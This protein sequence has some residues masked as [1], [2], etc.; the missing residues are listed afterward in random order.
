[1]NI[2]AY[3]G[4]GQIFDQFDASKARIVN[5]YYGSGVAYFTDN[6]KVAEG[7]AKAMSKKEGSRGRVIY[8]CQLSLGKIFDVENTYTGKELKRLVGSNVEA[9]ARGAG[10]MKAGIGDEKYQILGALKEGNYTL[11]GDL[12]FKAMSNG[13]VATRS[14][15]IK[16]QSLGYD[17]LRYNG[18]ILTGSIKHSVYLAYEPNMI[19]ILERYPI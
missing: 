5:D 16:L 15:R 18:G 17:G 10:L 13:M 4:S 9:F 14:A 1:M 12:V 2:I 7:Y 3:H 6:E 8:K 11:K 19:R